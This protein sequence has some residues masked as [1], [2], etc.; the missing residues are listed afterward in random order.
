MEVLELEITNCN[1][2]SNDLCD[3]CLNSLP[4]AQA[5]V[6]PQRSINTFSLIEGFMM[7]TIFP[8]LNRPYTK[9]DKNYKPN[10]KMCQ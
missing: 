10:S 2:L 9:I 7:G 1:N 6:P 4:V 5:Y 3:R 8:E